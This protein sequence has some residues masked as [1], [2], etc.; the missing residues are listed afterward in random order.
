M[1]KAK[2]QIKKRFSGEV[3]VEKE[4]ESLKELV[5]A[6][7]KRA[8]FEGTNL[9]GAD[10]KGINFKGTNLEGVNFKVEGTNLEGVNFKVEGTNLEEIEFWKADIERAKKRRKK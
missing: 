9:K 7:L 3:I 5:M 6:N 8:S 1:E 10:L 2:Y 4:A